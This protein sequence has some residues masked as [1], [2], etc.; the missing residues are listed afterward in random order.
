MAAQPRDARCLDTRVESSRACGPDAILL[1]LRLPEELPP[2]APGRFAMLSRADGLGPLVPRPFSVY[3]QPAPDRLLFL[4][5]LLGSG[6]R[7]LAALAPGDGVTCTAPLGRGF[8]VPGSGEP[9]VLVAGGVGSA[10][11]LGYA[12]ERVRAGAGARNIPGCQ[13]AIRPR[14]AEAATVRGLAR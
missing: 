6:T 2:L 13:A 9:V 8:A 5:Q 4:I 3:A 14:K 12:R 11:F 10:P 1:E 7:A